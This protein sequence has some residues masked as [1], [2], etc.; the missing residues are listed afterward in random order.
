MLHNGFIEIMI[1]S[2]CFGHY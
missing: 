2:R 1:R